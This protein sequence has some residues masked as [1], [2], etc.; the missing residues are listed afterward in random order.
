MTDSRV[1]RAR[2]HMIFTKLMWGGGDLLRI[3]IERGLWPAKT[4]AGVSM[5]G[6]KW[7]ITGDRYQVG[8]YKSQP[9]CA[10]IPSSECLWGQTAFPS[11]SRHD[12]DAA[13]YE[14]LWR[15]S[16]LP[17]DQMVFAWRCQPAPAGGWLVDWG[18]SK[19]TVQEDLRREFN[20]DEKDGTYLLASDRALAVRDGAYLRERR[21]QGQFNTIF[22]VMLVLTFLSLATS[23]L[24][25]V[26]IK[27]QEVVD[28]MLLVKTLEPRSAPVRQQLETLRGHTALLS[29][30]RRNVE[31]TLPNA[32]VIEAL[33]ATLPDDTWLDRLDINGTEVRIGGMTTNANDLISVLGRSNAFADIRATAP[34]LRDPSLNKERFAFELRWVAGGNP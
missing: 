13:V 20:L 10:V 22:S 9:N 27:R 25:P 31:A 11:M 28:A 5:D 14:D 15:Q 32:I 12:L 4:L 29:E 17:P 34:N 21:R 3:L 24:T 8:R 19:R 1:L 2:V 16:P 30:L 6:S 23:A 18:L 7:Q 26:L 33:S